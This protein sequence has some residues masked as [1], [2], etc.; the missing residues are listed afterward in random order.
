M[1]ATYR[2]FSAISGL[3]PL[4]GMPRPPYNKSWRRT[5]RCSSTSSGQTWM[6]VG[7]RTILWKWT[8]PSWRPW[9]PM[10]WVSTWCHCQNRKSP[11]WNHRHPLR[12]HPIASRIGS[13]RA[14]RPYRKGSSKGKNKRVANILPQELQNKGCVGVDDRNRRVCF[15]SNMNRCQAAANGAECQ[16]GFHLCLKKGCHAP[17]SA[18]DHEKDKGNKPWRLQRVVDL[19]AS[20]A[21]IA[22]CFIVEIFCGTVG[23]QGS[24]HARSSLVWRDAL[25]LTNCVQRTQ[26]H[27]SSS[28][29]LQLP[30]GKGFWWVGYKMPMSL[31][32]SWRHP[33]DRQAEPVRSLWRSAN[34]AETGSSTQVRSVSKR[35]IWPQASWAGSLWLIN[36]TT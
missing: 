28:Q 31:A 3:T 9:S 27:L 1:S 21:N 14:Y 12:M 8:L 26:C 24:Q 22:E 32:Y 5:G 13:L 6:S 35:L 15:N 10:K 18:F 19:A 34:L 16:R 30:K 25:E 33:V 2:R 36:C 11:K 17:H 4:K 20:G 23:P 29:S 7:A